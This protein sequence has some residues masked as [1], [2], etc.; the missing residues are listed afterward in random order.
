ME[1][2]ANVNGQDLSSTRHNGRMRA[3]AT[4]AKVSVTASASDQGKPLLTEMASSDAG[5]YSE[6]AG[7]FTYTR[8]RDGGVPTRGN[9]AIDEA[10]LRRLRIRSPRFAARF[11]L[12]IA[13]ILSDRLETA[14]Q[15]L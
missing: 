8:R 10:F 7:C 4:A 14:N 1:Q 6:V 2:I 3:R 13:R 11:P 9:S 12:N 5:L 15:R